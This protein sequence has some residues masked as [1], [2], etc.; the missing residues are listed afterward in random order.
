MTPHYSLSVTYEYFL[1]ICKWFSF[2][3]LISGS[4]AFFFYL[5]LLLFFDLLNSTLT[6]HKVE[7][8]QTRELNELIFFLM[9]KPL[10]IN[11]NALTNQNKVLS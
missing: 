9:L 8:T 5:Y 10:T 3:F 2:F 6:D 1:N 7:L 4:V 11:T